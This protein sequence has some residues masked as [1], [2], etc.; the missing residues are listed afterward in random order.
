M[1]INDLCVFLVWRLHFFSQIEQESLRKSNV[2]ALVR[3]GILNP[4]WIPEQPILAGTLIPTT[5]FRVQV[6][7]VNLIWAALRA[8]KEAGSAVEKLDVRLSVSQ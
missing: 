5:V 6:N 7:Q 2:F 4:I 1:P 3:D 8:H